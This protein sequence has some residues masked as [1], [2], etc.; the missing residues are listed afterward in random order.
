M[1]LLASLPLFPVR[2]STI[3]V[4]VDHLYFFLVAV[5]SF[6]A[7]LIFTLVFVFAIKYRR[8]SPADSPKPITGSLPLELLWTLIPLGISMVMFFWGAD[9]YFEH[10]IP[11]R[12]FAYSGP[13]ARQVQ[14]F[15]CFYFAMMGLHALHMVVGIGL[16]TVMAILVAR[17][18]FTAAHYA[19]VEVAG[20]YWHFVD[21]VW[22]FLFPLLYLVDLHK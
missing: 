11:G 7:L 20:L 17:G 18:R 12:G 8:R 16:L 19:P 22:I 10:L 5:A 6:F 21:I 4:G 9:L 3:G 1:T 2:A 15:V 13:Y 14:L